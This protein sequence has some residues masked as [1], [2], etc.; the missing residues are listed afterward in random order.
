[1][2]IVKSGEIAWFFRHFA[3]DPA[4]ACKQKQKFFCDGIQNAQIVQTVYRKIGVGGGESE[5]AKA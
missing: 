1:M 4:Y 3:T 5:N 2:K